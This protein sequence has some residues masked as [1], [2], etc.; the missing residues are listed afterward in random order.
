MKRPIGPGLRRGDDLPVTTV[1]LQGQV[2]PGVGVVFPFRSPPAA[3][4]SS[5]I[6]WA[7]CPGGARE[8]QFSCFGIVRSAM[9]NQ[10]V[11]V[12][13]NAE[14]RSAGQPQDFAQEPCRTEE[15]LWQPAAIERNSPAV[16]LVTL[17]R[18]RHN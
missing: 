8:N 12:K 5:E 1:V 9:E 14:R 13:S 2:R 10:R 6:E 7:M 18:L 11:G 15:E 4:G 17:P 16:F 3:A